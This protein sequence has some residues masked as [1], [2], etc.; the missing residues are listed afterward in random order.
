VRLTVDAYTFT[1]TSLTFGIGLGT[2]VPSS[3]IGITFPATQS[4]SSDAN[5]LDDYE[6]G[7][8]TPVLQGSSTAGTYTYYT[9]RTNGSY[10]KIGKMLTVFGVYRISTV[11]SAG[12]GD[13][14]ISGLPFTPVKVDTA[15]DRI[16]GTLRVQ[17]GPTLASN[18]YFCHTESPG[19]F[20]GIGLQGVADW[21]SVSVT[22][23]DFVNAVWFFQCTYEAA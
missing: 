22:D 15:W 19:T 18:G 20:L 2:G 17:S 3:G 6:E 4:A 21:T 7:T 16:P 14:K 13:A 23:A 9:D 8:W 10:V 12:T 11:T 5:T 1:K